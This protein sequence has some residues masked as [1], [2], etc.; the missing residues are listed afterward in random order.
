MTR[1]NPTAVTKAILALDRTIPTLPFDDVV[2]WRPTDTYPTLRRVSRLYHTP[3]DIQILWPH[4][5]LLHTCG[6][7]G[8]RLRCQG[9]GWRTM[10]EGAEERCKVVFLREQALLQSYFSSQVTADQSVAMSVARLV[11]RD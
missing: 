11:W 9:Q 3:L 4:G 7:I 1:V 10:G 5:Y 6:V 2:L 8:S